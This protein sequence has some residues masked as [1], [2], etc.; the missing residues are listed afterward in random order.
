M[1]MYT[2]ST[3][4][5]ARSS[6]INTLLK[7]LIV[8]HLEIVYYHHGLAS[9]G[10]RRD[11]LPYALGDLG[12]PP[13]QRV[14]GDDVDPQV[15][16]TYDDPRDFLAALVGCGLGVT[17]ATHGV[18]PFGGEGRYRCGP[19]EFNS[20]CQDK[21]SPPVDCFLLDPLLFLGLLLALR[22]LLLALPLLLG[23]LLREE[24][25]GDRYVDL[26]YTQTDQALHPVGDVA[27]DGLGELGYRLA[28]LRGQRQVYS[29]LFLANLHRD[30]LGLA[31]TAAAARDA[32][33]DAAHGLGAA[34]AHPDA[35]DLLGGDAGDLRYHA[36]RDAGRAPLGLERAL[37]PLFAHTAPFVKVPRA[38]PPGVLSAG[39]SQARLSRQ[40]SLQ[41]WTRGLCRLLQAPRIATAPRNHRRMPPLYRSR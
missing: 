21:P 12:Y 15:F 13:G 14:A 29:C 23:F 26:V 36:V 31:T 27:P 20:V 4:R 1:I 16:C 8:G 7:T 30:A 19:R 24:D 9:A 40:G 3:K 32:P 18:D 33:E 34:A 37:G 2:P 25:V 41:G 10:L 39:R 11:A 17:A 6:I 5:P 35:I 38:I 28:V 22:L